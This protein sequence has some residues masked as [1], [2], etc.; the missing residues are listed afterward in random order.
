[1]GRLGSGCQ[2][3]QVCTD[4]KRGK[5]LGLYC[6]G[7]VAVL[8]CGVVV[9]WLCGICDILGIWVMHGLKPKQYTT[10]ANKEYFRRT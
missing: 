7:S 4:G 5:R 8:L 9:M 2:W 3:L 10:Q 6:G 1:M